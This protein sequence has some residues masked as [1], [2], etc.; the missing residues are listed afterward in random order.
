MENV[1]IRVR[2]DLI[3]VKNEY[4]KII[5]QQF[6]LTVKGVHKSNENCDSYKFKQNE[7]FM[8]KPT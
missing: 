7:A 3:R 6:N 4:R 5:K 8:D 2:L 1:G